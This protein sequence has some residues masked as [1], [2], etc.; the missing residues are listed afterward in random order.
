MLINTFHFQLANY[1]LLKKFKDRVDIEYHSRN[2]GYYHLPN[3]GFKVIESVKNWQNSLENIESVVVIGVGGSSLGAKAVSTMLTCDKKFGTPNLFFLENIDPITINITLSKLKF[4]KALFLLVSKSGTTLDTISIA[5]IIMERF[6]VYPQDEE[7][8]NHFAVITDEDSA[9]H[10]FA[11][12][13][14]LKTFFISQNVGGRFSVLSA[15]G[16]VPLTLCGFN[17]ESLLEGAAECERDF[18]EKGDMTIVQKAYAYVNAQEKINVLFS[19]SNVFKSFNEWYIQLWAESLGK[20]KGSKNVGLTPVGLIGAVDQHSFLQLIIDGPK[21][22]SVTFIRVKEMKGDMSIP[23]FSLKHIEKADLKSSIS[24]AKLL[25]EQALATMKSVI[26]SGVMTD[27]ITLDKLDAYHTGYLIYYYQLL[28]S[29]C[30][31][32]LGVDSYNQPGV[33]IGKKILIRK[34]GKCANFIKK[35]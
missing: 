9:L 1:D 12:E 3:N 7:F 10:K 34:L 26:D 4:S 31:I 29:T 28:T 30:G 20:K 2:I 25:S 23:S 35:F 16:L 18:F 13:Y 27:E 6:K 14:G 19:Y 15:A 21:D 22:K 33:E 17:A 24:A 11:A 5:K 8:S 32:M